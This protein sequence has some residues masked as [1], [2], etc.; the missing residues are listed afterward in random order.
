MKP[1]F[2]ADTAEEFFLLD[3]STFLAN[4]G[5]GVTISSFTFGLKTG[6]TSG[7]VVGTGSRAPAIV[8]SGTGILFWLEGGTY[9]AEAT[10]ACH[11]VLSNTEEFPVLIKVKITNSL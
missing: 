11:L 5:T 8:N 10:I 4:E 2:K 6:D 7:V 1:F 9:G 3:F